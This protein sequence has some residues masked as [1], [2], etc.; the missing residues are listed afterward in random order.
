MLY[1]N[2]AISNGF[3]LFF[4]NEYFSLS[5]SLSHSLPLSL[6]RVFF[7]FHLL[8]LR[9]SLMGP[10]RAHTA[11]QWHKLNLFIFVS[12]KFIYFFTLCNFNGLQWVRLNVVDSSFGFFAR[13]FTF[14][15]RNE[16]IYTLVCLILFWWVLVFHLH[17]VY[18]FFTFVLFIAAIFIRTEM[19]QTAKIV[20]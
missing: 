18:L 2:H 13:S 16:T 15:R 11:Q 14:V 6:A 12:L 1:H 9:T 5:F 7:F 4:V 17:F 10:L 20:D 3:Q 8:S 19:I